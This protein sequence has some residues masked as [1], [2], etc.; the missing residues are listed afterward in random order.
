MRLGSLKAGRLESSEA[1]KLGGWEVEK[2]EGLED[3]WSLGLPA[4]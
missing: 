2:I 3:L 4:F 1:S